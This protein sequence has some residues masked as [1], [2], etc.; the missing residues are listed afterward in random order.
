MT[1]T[2]VRQ[3]R[4]NAFATPCLSGGGGGRGTGRG[5][6]GGGGPGGGTGMDKRTPRGHRHRHMYGCH[7]SE[8]F[9]IARSRVR[10]VA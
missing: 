3:E 7:G 4:A 8:P 10:S 1:A 2:A 6:G 9:D 5:C